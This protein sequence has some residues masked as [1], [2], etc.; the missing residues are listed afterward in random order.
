MA[1]GFRML[2]SDLKVERR[3]KFL[4]SGTPF[5]GQSE[6]WR[7]AGEAKERAARNEAIKVKANMELPYVL[8]TEDGTE[9][10]GF[11]Y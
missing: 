1:N 5:H 11:I 3:V 9:R 7:S 8:V 2:V 6:V 4:A 10:P